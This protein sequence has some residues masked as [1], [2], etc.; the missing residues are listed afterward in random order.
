MKKGINRRNFIKNSTLG[1]LGGTL[2]NKGLIG[3]EEKVKEDIKEDPVIKD[4]RLLGRTGFRTSDISL[5]YSGNAQ[6]IRKALESGVNYIDTAESYKNQKVVGEA[7]KGTDR[8]K[9]FITSKLEIKKDKSEAGFIKR[10]NQCIKELD[11]D[12]IDCMM[13]HSAED[14][15]TLKTPGF[16]SAMDQMKKE[17]KLKYVGVS[18]HGSNWFKAPKVAMAT[19]LNEAVKDG[20]F[21]VFLMAYNFIQEDLGAEVIKNCTKENI[22]VTLMKVNPV[23]SYYK[24]RD[25]IKKLESKKKKV[26]PLYREGIVRFK[27]KAESAEEFIEKY[28]LKNPK[29]IKNAAIKYVLANK[30]VSAVACSMRNFDHIEEFLSLSGKVLTE[31]ERKQLSYYREGPG[32][33]Y[34]RHG[35]NECESSCPSE[36]KISDM[37]RYNHYFDAHNREK[38]A[39]KKYMALNGKDAG[40]CV[41]CEGYCESSCSYDL[42]V[43]GLL[44]MV[45]NNL[46]LG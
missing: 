1:I 3:A 5:G 28:D 27:K 13:I 41:D 18:N 22:G 14:I 4:Y 42:P 11:T 37:M 16:H 29:E 9:T 23:G 43:Q 19:I 8:K 46:S 25:T 36:L 15:E 20:R 6:V 21:D 2:A 45:H 33:L 39:I 26:D 12:Y 32:Q 30:G 24:I 35:C 44:S 7:I 34:C 31:P 40:L 38:Y 17:G 10:F